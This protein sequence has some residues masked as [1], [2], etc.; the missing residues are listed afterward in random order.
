MDDIN[1]NK[2]GLKRVVIFLVGLA[3]VILIAGGLFFLYLVHQNYLM[4]HNPYLIDL[5]YKFGGAAVVGL[6]L[7]IGDFKLR[8]YL[9]PTAEDIEKR[10]KRQKAKQEKYEA[11][12][13][14]DVQKQRE[15][16]N[17]QFEKNKDQ[18]DEARRAERAKQAMDEAVAAYGLASS[19]E[20]DAIL[21]AMRA[22]R[23]EK[24]KLG[25]SIYEVIDNTYVKK[26]DIYNPEVAS[27][28]CGEKD[29]VSRKEAAVNSNSESAIL[30]EQNSNL[31]ITFF[32]GEQWELYI[33]SLLGI[34][35]MILT[36]F[37]MYNYVTGLD[38]LPRSESEAYTAT[39]YLKL[40]GFIIVFWIGIYFWL[41]G[42]S[43]YY[44]VHTSC[45]ANYYDR[46][47]LVTIKRSIKQ[48]KRSVIESAGTIGK[49]VGGIAR[50]IEL[51]EAKQAVKNEFK[52]E[53]FP[54]LVERLI[55]RG[56]YHRYLEAY[57]LIPYKHIS[58]ILKKYLLYLYE[59]NK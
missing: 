10:E 8:H 22:E 49:A 41:M 11:A 55:T 43:F 35:I 25:A 44:F 54:G 57:E 53:D 32:K 1:E 19:E 31:K 47:Y 2:A 42:K 50:R 48:G 45:I 3:G 9:L 17:R 26:P 52:D 36:F 13:A 7:I 4:Y 27:I 34:A 46:L 58:R 38:A 20:K 12:Y 56:S 28:N 37:G 5:Y 14:R 51:S 6:L 15:K 24:N 59:K 18:F 40:A 33:V 21:K 29:D 23:E 39:Y 16:L 30:H